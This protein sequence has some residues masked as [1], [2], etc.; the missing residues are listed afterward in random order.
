MAK[1]RI[2]KAKRNLDPENCKAEGRVPYKRNGKQFCR[3]K[4]TSKRQAR[5]TMVQ[6]Q[7]LARDAG[8]SSVSRRTGN[9]MKKASLYAKL[10]KYGHAF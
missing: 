4:P 8:I 1:V 7:A 10:K 9:T 2:K 5:Y 6:L 3:S